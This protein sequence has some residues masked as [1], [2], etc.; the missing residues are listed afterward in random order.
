MA[1]GFDLH[2]VKP[3]TIDALKNYDRAVVKN[4][5]NTPVTD[6][7]RNQMLR[8]SRN[9]NIVK[10]HGGRAAMVLAGRGV[11]PDSAVKIL[12]TSYAEEDDLLREIMNAEV[13]YAK[14]KRFWD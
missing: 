2:L 14:T 1:A 7:N 13:L 8:I 12:R 4:L 3:V 5:T 9:A 10:E 11:G 6:E